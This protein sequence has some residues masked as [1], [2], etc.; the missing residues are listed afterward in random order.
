MRSFLFDNR[1]ETKE[2]SIVVSTAISGLHYG[3]GLASAD[4]PAH[5]IALEDP[6]ATCVQSGEV[7][8]KANLATIHGKLDE[9]H[10]KITATDTTPPW[11]VELACKVLW[12]ASHPCLS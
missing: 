8:V 12:R 9:V 1:I 2:T 3:T 10:T 11:H 5:V 6:L 4:L 7:F